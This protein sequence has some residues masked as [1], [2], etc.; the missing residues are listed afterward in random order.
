MSDRSEGPGWWLASDGKW[1][2]PQAPAPPGQ[3]PHIAVADS[4]FEIWKSVV[5]TK[6]SQFNGRAR[7]AEYWWFALVNVL[8]AVGIS[9][10]AL[11]LAAVSS[12][13]SVIAILAYVV[14]A[15]GIIIP[16]IAITVRRLHD[17]NKSGVWYFIVLVPVVGGITLLVLLLLDGDQGTNDYGPSEKYIA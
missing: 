14:F 12:A 6:Y 11:I 1:Y 15:I 8:I 17:T 13:L 16:G 7:R 5:M 3:Q 2:P 10:V 9:G 4:P